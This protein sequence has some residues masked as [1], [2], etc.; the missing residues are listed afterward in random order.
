M[1]APLKNAMKPVFNIMPSC[2]LEA[3]KYT[4]TI[5][6]RLLSPYFLKAIRKFAESFVLLI[7][8]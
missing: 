7:K 3:I 5:I 8:E 2:Y 6:P 4:V 1:S